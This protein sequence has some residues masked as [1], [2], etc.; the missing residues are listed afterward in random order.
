MADSLNRADLI[1]LPIEDLDTP[2]LLLD[3]PAL[4]R[5]LKTMAAFFKG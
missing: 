2:A 5:N 4:D 3:G 1:G